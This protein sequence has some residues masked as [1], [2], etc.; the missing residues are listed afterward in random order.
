MRCESEF[1]GSCIEGGEQFV[2]YRV[3]V[4]FQEVTRVVSDFACIVSHCETTRVR[5]SRLRQSEVASVP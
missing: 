3:P 4:G 5:W 1:A 2:R